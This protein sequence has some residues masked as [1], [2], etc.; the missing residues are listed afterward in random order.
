MLK[1]G[2]RGRLGPVPFDGRQHGNQ[3]QGGNQ[4]EA[5]VEHETGPE[6]REKHGNRYHGGHQRGYHYNDQSGHRG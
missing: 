2:P 6:A 5:N 4:W 3:P 1:S